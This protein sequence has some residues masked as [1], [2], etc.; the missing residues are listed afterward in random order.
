M[1]PTLS[2]DSFAQKLLFY[3]IG[4]G[5]LSAA[6]G[7]AAVVSAPVGQTGSTFYFTLQNTTASTTA[8]ANSNSFEFYNNTSKSLATNSTNGTPPTGSG[9]N[10]LFATESKPGPNSKA[11]NYVLKLGVGTT[12]GSQTFNA[13]GTFNNYYPGSTFMGT[14]IPAGAKNGDWKPGNQG[15]VGLEITDGSGGVHYGFA[16]L[17]F[18]SVGGTYTFNGLA[19]QTT[20]GAAITTFAIPEPGSTTALLVAGAAGAAALRARRRKA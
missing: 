14:T 13:S 3:G 20:A 18:N 2:P 1:K 6:T 12:I 7:Q 11:T 4:V 9:T 8:P 19:Y 17:T 10:Y 5:A 15:F 16:D